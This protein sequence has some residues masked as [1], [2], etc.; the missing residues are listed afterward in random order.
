MTWLRNFSIRS[1]LVACMGLVV[2]IGLLIGAGT[3]TD[4]LRL[5]SGFDALASRDF[6]AV[7][8]FGRLDSAL[9]TMRAAEKDMLVNA[10]DTVSIGEHHK[11]WQAALQQAQDV[12]KGVRDKAGDLPKAGEQLAAVDKHVQAYVG[13]L[14]PVLDLLEGGSLTSA[15]EAA[16]MVEVATAKGEMDAAQ[17]GVAALGKAARDAADVRRNDVQSQIQR[18]IIVLWALLLI[19]GIVFLP[20]MTATVLS[21][22][23]PLRH[24]E[25]VAAAIASGDL[26]KDIVVDGRDEAAHLL[27]A[28]QQMQ[29][30]LRAM[31][32]EVR[33]SS[34]DMLVAST[35]I[36]AGNQDLSARTEQAAANLQQTTSSMEQLNQTVNESAQAARGAAELAVSA[37]QRAEHGGQ[38]VGEVV[39]NMEQI[40][41]SSRKI[42]DIIGVIDNIAFQTNIL[43]LNA[44][45]EAARAGEQGRGFAVVASEVRN[46]AQRSA[47]AAKE[48]K[49]LIGSS[50][51]RVEAGSQRV[52]DAGAV[53]SEI[54]GSIQ[55]LTQ[56]M[57][58]IADAT[59]TQSHGLGQVS[60]AVTS[61]DHM[62]Q[63]N[64]ALVE[65]SAA[66]AD[67]LKQQA[68][69]LARV[70]TRFKLQEEPA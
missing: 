21:I 35:E 53:M 59:R 32:D 43:A 55:R 37:S 42:A 20:L 41:E 6:A 66:A 25:R 2:V 5:R 49:T 38:V 8:E 60:E 64:A 45:V 56:A 27:E 68:D 57:G 61:L 31:V 40:T 51:E 14:K 52:R 26:S 54:V 36:A 69:S 7:A 46:L 1:R 58:G 44:A 15:A 12:S 33:H 62:T 23:R 13:A 3:T 18:S 11:R 70:V 16:Q 39:S 63:Q 65:Q 47:Q 34:A 19:P 9:L 67:S 22:M 4:L 24:A 30:S 28:M 50:V 29:A 48:I 17:Q 10:G